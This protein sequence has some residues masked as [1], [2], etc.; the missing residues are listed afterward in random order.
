MWRCDK[1]CQVVVKLYQV[2]VKLCE[3]VSSRVKL[4][5]SCVRLCQVVSDCVELC[6]VVKFCHAP[7]CVKCLKLK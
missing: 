5:Q 7:S 1:W 6:E 2:F 4:C 3:V